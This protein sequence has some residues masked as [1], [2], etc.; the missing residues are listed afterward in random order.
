MFSQPEEE[1]II[2]ACTNLYLKPPRRV[3]IGSSENILNTEMSSL[4]LRAFRAQK[5]CLVQRTRLW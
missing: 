2:V 5:S 1:N 4:S 3:F